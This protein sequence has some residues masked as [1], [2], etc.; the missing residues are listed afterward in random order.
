MGFWQKIANTFT[1][2]RL[3]EDISEEMA[4]HLEQRERANRERGLTPQAARLAARRKFGNLTL[5]QERTA[6]SDIVRWLEAIGR[7]AQFAFRLLRKSPAFTLTAV[8]T[9]ALGIG[10]NTAVFTLMK[11]IVMD[12]LPVKQPEQLVILHDSGP[13]F[14]G[15]GYRMGNAM[16]SAFSYPLYRDLNSGT[17]QIF[18]GVLARA[19]GPFTSVTL[20][21]TAGAERISAE[22]ISGNYF[23][24]LGVRPWRGRLLT[25]SDNQPDSDATAVLS[26]GFWEAQFAGDP[27]IVNQTI[28]LSNQPFVVAGIAPPSFYGISLGNTTDVYVPVAMVHR[29]VPAAPDPLPDRNYAWLSLIARLKPG[30]TMQQAQSALAVIYPPLRDKQLAYIHA[31]W[32]GFLENFKRQYIELTPGGK[33]YS[34]LREGL[35]KPLQY[36]FA[37]TGIFLLI[38]LVNI[39]NL[40]IA[41]ASRRAR[42]MAVRLSLGA[43]RRTLVRQLLMESCVLAAIGGAC[44]IVLAYLGTPLLIK[45]FSANLSQGGMEAHPDALVLGLSLAISLACGLLFGLGPAWQSAQTRVAENL[46]WTGGTHTARGQWGRRALI[47][48][49]VALSFVLLASALLLTVSLRNLRH[50]DVGFRTDHLIRFKI[51]PSA[52]GYSEIAAANFAETVRDKIAH[53]HDVESAAVAVVPVMENSDTGFNV[54]VEGYQ[55]PT[56]ADAQTH[57]DAVSPN[58]FAT[59]GIPLVA[60]RPF[61]A[62]EMQHGYKVAVVNQTFVRHFFGTRNPIGMHFSIG[63]G[64]HG[65]PWTI[66]GAVRDSEYLNLRGH[67]EPLVY[68]PYT[69]RGELHE[70]TFYVRAKRQ[71]RTVIREIRSAVQ[72]LDQRAPVSALATMDQLINDELFAERSLSLAA[73]V[74]A[75]LACALAAVGL[76]GVMAYM[77]AQRRREFG[78]RLAVGA[79]PGALARM[80]LREGTLVALAGLALG[81][82]CAFGASRWGREALYGLRAAEV[83][84]WALAGL[85]ILLVALVTAWVPARMAAGIDPQK[86]LREE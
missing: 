34:S 85:G 30:V 31:P 57:S 68:L 55:P 16:S 75:V 71:E 4:F 38:T 7:D 70:L 48:A 66:V 65:L 15:S 32:R 13:R 56:H 12:A 19:Q 79:T 2:R 60:G 14:S 61:S 24:L 53:L 18:S 74:F 5:T 37:M 72:R 41:R 45:Q 46:K 1:R 52:A 78:I 21:G 33:G 28:R 80:V 43:P 67:I 22:L 64:S 17:G 26:Y 9:L 25:E 44:G 6:D 63:G 69:V 8:L 47:A 11:L 40:L 84:I 77:V 76:Y 82:P 27:R 10:A 42:E 59:M 49:Q 3:Q 39:A 51:D 36:V 58:F 86:T 29:L 83:L 20:A 54:A 35:E 62:A 73:S 81:L 23:S 50:I